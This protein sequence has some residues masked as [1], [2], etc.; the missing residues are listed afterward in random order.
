MENELKAVRASVEQSGELTEAA[1][2][3]VIFH[4]K[5]YGLTRDLE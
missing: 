4:G 1:I 3:T 5:P 2:Q